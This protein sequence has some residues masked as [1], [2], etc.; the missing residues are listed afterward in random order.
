[1]YAQQRDDIYS[2]QTKH[3]HGIPTVTVAPV[4]VRNSIIFYYAT[5]AQSF[6]FL[7]VATLTGQACYMRK[8]YVKLSKLAFGLELQVT[9]ALSTKLGGVWEKHLGAHCPCMSKI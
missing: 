7:R 6:I 8:C 2:A 1:M 3:I 4:Y 9:T 5:S